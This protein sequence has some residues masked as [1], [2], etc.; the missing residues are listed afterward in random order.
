MSG[1]PFGV[2]NSADFRNV[3][4]MPTYR[5]VDIGTN[6]VLSTRL[7]GKQSKKAEALTAGIEILNVIGVANTL[8]YIWIRDFQNNQYAVPNTLSQRFFNLKVNF[9]W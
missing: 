2:P 3:Y 4:T 5:R 8:S 9:L 7:F 6:W 1:L